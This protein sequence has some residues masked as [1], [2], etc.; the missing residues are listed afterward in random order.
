ML[1]RL[2]HRPGEIIHKLLKG[3]V[4]RDAHSDPA[5]R[6]PQPFQGRTLPLITGKVWP[7]T[8]SNRRRRPFQ[9]R[10]LPLSYLALANRSRLRATE[11]PR[12]PRIGPGTQTSVSQ[13]VHGVNRSGEEKTTS[14]APGTHRLTSNQPLKR[15]FSIATHTLH[16]KL[17]LG[18]IVILALAESPYV[19]F[20]LAIHPPDHPLR[21]AHAKSVSC[22][23]R[24]LLHRVP[25]R[26]NRRVGHRD[27]RLRRL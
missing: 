19:S 4:A 25:A 14:G 12:L 1:V 2:P 17:H 16:A 7:E 10:A 24:A 21:L 26:A 6:R 20:E 23:P 11:A 22:Y 3:V 15:F 13:P 18:P 8:G 27:S 5:N 9:G